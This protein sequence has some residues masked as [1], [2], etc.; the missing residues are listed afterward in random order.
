M[1]T[2]W[3]VFQDGPNGSSQAD[4]GAR[5][6]PRHAVI[7]RGLPAT[8]AAT[9]SPRAYP[10][11]GPAAAAIRAGPRPSRAA[12]RGSPFHIRRG[13]PPTPSASLPDN[14]K[15][16]LTLFSKSFSSFPRGTCSPSASR[17]F[18]LGRNLPPDWG[19]IPKQPDSPTAVGRQG[20]GTTGVSPSPG[21]SVGLGP[22]PPPRDA[23]PDYTL[24][25]GATDSHGGSFLPRRRY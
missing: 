5:P 21:A 23:S 4:A 9:T 13:A 25:A 8:I 14:F 7:A 11:P 10:R 3:S 19:R 16:S 24:D 17:A 1:S 12:D 22:G 6:V 18:S 20:P 15:H 2:P